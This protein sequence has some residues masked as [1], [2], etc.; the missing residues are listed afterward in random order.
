M[1][2]LS[3]VVSLF[4]VSGALTV[5]SGQGAAKSNGPSLAHS[6]GTSAPST[7]SEPAGGSKRDRGGA[8]CGHACP[9]HSR[10]L[11]PQPP[12]R[13]PHMG[14]NGVMIQCK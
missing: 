10:P 9:P 2:T 7:P 3:I 8:G 4:A 14:P 1:K 5:T 11:P 13:G 6:S 12:C